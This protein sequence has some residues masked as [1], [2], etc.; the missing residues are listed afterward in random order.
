M[1]WLLL[2]WRWLRWNGATAPHAGTTLPNLALTAPN[3]G[4]YQ[5]QDGAA[6]PNMALPL[7]LWRCPS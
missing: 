7:L 6:P 1:V 2:L 5:G 4:S 3:G